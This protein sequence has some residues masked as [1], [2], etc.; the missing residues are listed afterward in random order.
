MASTQERDGRELVSAWISR[1]LARRLERAARESERTKSA[2]MRVALRRH[3][4]EL[5]DEGGHMSRPLRIDA[6]TVESGLL[7][8]DRGPVTHTVDGP[9][10]QA[11]ADLLDWCR[12]TSV[13]STRI[14]STSCD[15]GR[16]GG[17]STSATR[18]RIFAFSRAATTSRPRRRVCGISSWSGIAS[19]CSRDPTPSLS[20]ARR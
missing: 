13:S 7:M 4:D 6:D 8:L 14:R 17:R 10:L 11:T 5:S 2:E 15:R 3:L 16:T 1:E 19:F 20:R 9:E 12:A 18:M